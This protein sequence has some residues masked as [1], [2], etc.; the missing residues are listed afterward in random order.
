MKR[1]AQ[2]HRPEKGAS[3]A[4]GT[5]REFLERVG[6]ILVECGYRPRQLEREFG[7]ICGKL[8]D[9]QQDWNPATLG[10][11]ADLP[12]V[13]T[14][15]HRDPDYVDEHGTPRPLSLNNDGPSLS[16][17]IARIY[18]S[19]DPAEVVETLLRIGAIRRLR[20]RF[21]PAGRSLVLEDEAVRIHALVALLA[22]LRTIDFNIQH[23][24]ENVSRLLEK[25]VIIPR[26]P[27]HRLEELHRE[28]HQ[29]GEQFATE[30]DAQLLR[31]EVALG[32]QEEHTRVIFGLYVSD[33]TLTDISPAAPRP[34]GSIE[35]TGSGPAARPRTRSRASKTK[36]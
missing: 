30:I 31:S 6:R 15:W 8:E 24:H 12:H 1:P 9:P 7:E 14:H 33:D 5:S 19:A 10:Y 21:V 29:R 27:K 28:L 32:S 2:P 4:L 36:K 3:R 11:I 16:S 20:K 18:P 26:F 23:A 35:A 17:L 13:L 34:A 25:T 22:I